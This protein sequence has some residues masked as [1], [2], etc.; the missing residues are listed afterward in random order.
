MPIEKPNI[1]IILAD[2]LG[3]G[4]LGCY[5]ATKIPTPNIDQVAREGM[6]FTDAHSSSAVCTPS[7][8]S[9]LTG[10]YCWR[11]SLQQWVIHGF[12][13]PLI[14]KDRLTLG[15]FLKHQGYH[16]AAIGK[17]H[18]GLG[19]QF[20]TQDPNRDL[21]QLDQSMEAQEEVD[22]AAELTHCPN[23]VGFDY[24]FGIA[25]SLDMPPYTFIENRHTVGDPCIP[26]HICYN[27]Q[28]C[29]FQTENWKDEEVDIRFTQQAKEF[30]SQSQKDTPKDPFF[31]YLATAAPHRPCDI[32][33]DFVINKS[34][35]GDRG[36]MVVMFDW[37]VGQ[38]VEHLKELGLFENTL[39]FIT[40]DN[41]ARATCAN[42]KDY[43]HKSCGDWR[44]Q[45]ADIWEGGHREPLIAHWPT[46]IPAGSYN[47]QLT[48][49]SDFMAT[50]SE[51]F[52]TPLTPDAGED[53]FSFLSTLQ[54]PDY[55]ELLDQ[56]KDV[57]KRTELVHH[58]GAG[59]FSL[60][61]SEWKLI[62]GLGS[63]GF[64]K[65]RSKK[66]WPWRPQGQLYNLNSDPQ[67][68][69]N[70]WKKEDGKKQE[71]QN[72]LIQSQIQNRTRKNSP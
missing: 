55:Q 53:S 40:S 33:P 27:Q 14:E 32:R 47:N 23:D 56:S 57:Q 58:S 31:L 38:I 11:T 70:L 19:W 30:I 59:F 36:D 64:S 18:V 17:W 44:G 51:M 24:F 69:T 72:L 68:Q 35:A 20:K 26:K 29:G 28:R 37:V 9:I 65:P 7:R 10:R 2:D 50:F 12:D 63:G 21:H 25:G 66:A 22:Y 3:Y 52:E 60:R 4:D 6:R 54:I 49:L 62:N 46:K 67:E 15:S 1:V 71:L 61:K 39:L 45:K 41:G 8:Y 48:C 34:Q 43:G 16:T 5:G 42:G 13:A